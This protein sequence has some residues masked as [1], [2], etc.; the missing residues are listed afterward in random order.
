MGI[1]LHLLISS[2]LMLHLVHDESFVIFEILLNVDF[3]LDDV[4]QHLL[5][6]GV[7]FLT[8]RVRLQRQL[9]VSVILVAALI[10][11]SH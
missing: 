9:L 7:Q 1:I 8:K 5:D 6:L 10:Q 3:E 2:Q 11:I 4:V